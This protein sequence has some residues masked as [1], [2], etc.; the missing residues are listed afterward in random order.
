MCFL[1]PCVKLVTEDRYWKTITVLPSPAQPLLK[2]KNESLL[3]SVGFSVGVTSSNI[4]NGK[5]THTADEK[6]TGG[7]ALS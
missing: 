5:K 2:S 7:V 1:S 4:N 6:D 3:I